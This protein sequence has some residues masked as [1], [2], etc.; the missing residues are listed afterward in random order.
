MSVDL[1]SL[2]TVMGVA[3]TRRDNAG[4]ALVNARQQLTAAEA[5]MAQITDYGD[6]NQAKWVERAAQGVT[7]VLMQHQRHFMDKIHA[8]IDFQANVIQ[9]RQNQVARAAQALLHTE[10][11]LAKIQKVEQRT[12]FGIALKARKAEQKSTDEMAMS[13]LAHQRRQAATEAHP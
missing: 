10:Q 3:I 4:A 2:R 12:I 7:P 13:M 5:Q 1:K 9:Q 8:A 6:Q 11:A